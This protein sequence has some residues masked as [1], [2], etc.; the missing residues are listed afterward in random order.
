MSL[1]KAIKSN[2][3]KPKQTIYTKLREEEMLSVFIYGQL[4][5]NE[6][7]P[8]SGFEFISYGDNH[9]AFRS[10]SVSN[11]SSSATSK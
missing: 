11:S 5:R 8:R 3:T 1:N 2:Q 7:Q 6:T 10:S 9:Y 4:A